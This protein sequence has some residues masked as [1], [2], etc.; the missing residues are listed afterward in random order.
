[1]SLGHFSGCFGNLSSTIFGNVESSIRAS[2]IYTHAHTDIDMAWNMLTKCSKWYAAKIIAHCAKWDLL[3]SLSLSVTSA[4]PF[5]TC[6]GRFQ[7]STQCWNSSEIQLAKRKWIEF[8]LWLLLF[9]RFFGFCEFAEHFTLICTKCKWV[10]LKEQQAEQGQATPIGGN[11][12]EKALPNAKHENPFNQSQ[13]QGKK[14][15]NQN[16][17]QSLKLIT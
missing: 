9:C 8:C 17:Q 4:I 1:M 14:K 5:P 16:R 2:F 11:V 13:A 10:T 15:P 12:N 3:L 6:T 7:H